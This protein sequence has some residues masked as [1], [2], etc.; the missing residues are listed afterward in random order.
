MHPT[1]KVIASLSALSSICDADRTLGKKIVLTSGCFDLLHG[2][3]LE[4]ICDAGERGF[5][6]VGINSD[7]FVRKLKG[8]GRPIRKENDRA[9]LMAG[10]FPVRRVIIFDCDYELIEA[11]KPDIYI[12]SMTSHVRVW[13]DKRRV[14]L[15]NEHGSEIIELDSGKTDSTTGIINR[16][17]NAC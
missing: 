10:F 6:I 17:A 15:L 8:E 12:A 3:H 4:Y 11:V 14:S 13:D 2:G 1:D 9:F 5:L 7:A 16:S